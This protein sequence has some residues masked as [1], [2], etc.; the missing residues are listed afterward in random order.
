MSAC[1][2]SCSRAPLCQMTTW[3]MLLTRRLHL[4]QMLHP[5]QMAQPPSSRKHH[6][7]MARVSASHAEQGPHHDGG[8]LLMS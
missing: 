3:N 6:L 4:L 5:M 2:S 1:A 8:S 7:Q